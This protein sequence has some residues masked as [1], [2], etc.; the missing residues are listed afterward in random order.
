MILS[1]SQIIKGQKKDAIS[2]LRPYNETIPIYCNTPITPL[3]GALGVQRALSRLKG[4][5][6]WYCKCS[7]ILPVTGAMLMKKKLS[8]MRKVQNDE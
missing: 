7:L 8:K 4:S 1:S 2:S 3:I 6:V 5:Q